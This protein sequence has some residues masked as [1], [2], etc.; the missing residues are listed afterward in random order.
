MGRWGR[1]GE[2]H[3]EWKRARTD[4]LL[5]TEGKDG[6]RQQTRDGDRGK[7]SD[8]SGIEGMREKRK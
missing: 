2:G 1:A 8:E 4:S 6:E 5:E 3:W 7:S